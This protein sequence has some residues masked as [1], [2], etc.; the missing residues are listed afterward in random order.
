[1]NNTDTQTLKLKLTQS[2]NI[3]SQSQYGSYFIIGSY[4]F[5]NAHVFKDR[6]SLEELPY[7][8]A[9]SSFFRPIAPSVP[10]IAVAELN[11]GPSSAL[12]GFFDDWPAKESCYCFINPT[13]HPD[14]DDWLTIL[15]TP[16]SMENPL[17]FPCLDAK[18]P[19]GLSG[20]PLLHAK[21][22]EPEG[23]KPFWQIVPIGVIYAK[24]SAHEHLYAVSLQTEMAQ[25]RELLIKQDI[26]RR[27]ISTQAF[28]SSNTTTP[29][30]LPPAKN[31][32]Q[33]GHLSDDATFLPIADNLTLL[34]LPKDTPTK[35][36]LLSDTLRIERDGVKLKA[37]K[38]SLKLV[39]ESFLDRNIM[40]VKDLSKCNSKYLRVDIDTSTDGQKLCCIEDN[41]PGK[42][43]E[44]STRFMAVK[45]H[46]NINFIQKSTFVKSL[47]NSALYLQT[48][49]ISEE[50]NN[51]SSHNANNPA[52]S[53]KG[54][55]K[56]R[57]SKPASAKKI[58]R[59]KEKEQKIISQAAKDEKKRL[60]KSHFEIFVSAKDGSIFG[61]PSKYTKYPKNP[62]LN[63][64]KQFF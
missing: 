21:L 39:L 55:H 22:K 6:T 52:N 17:V 11:N 28:L 27:T 36:A 14:S 46:P 15:D 2:P 62:S 58:L 40:A 29:L 7:P 59:K 5:S 16:I 51:L 33:S 60:D 54:H 24:D 13:L 32:Y 23:G 45:I 25:I 34:R 4:L 31:A 57:Q 37:I 1:M 49:V 26:D 12:T 9:Q 64:I 20:A 48:I 35:I 18:M 44:D 30:S 63:I 8:I 50:E 10:D 43:H 53:K 42:N 3:A 19:L 38:A 56:K 41:M 47:Y 61:D